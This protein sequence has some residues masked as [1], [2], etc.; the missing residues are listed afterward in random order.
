MTLIRHFLLPLFER[1]EDHVE[2]S[3]HGHLAHDPL[4]QSSLLN[5]RAIKRTINPHSYILIVVLQCE[6]TCFTLHSSPPHI[7]GA[8][9][10]SCAIPSIETEVDA[11]NC[12]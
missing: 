7:T 8:S 12:A 9:I 4:V 1:R 5:I 3:P 6:Y 11:D 10:R 2:L